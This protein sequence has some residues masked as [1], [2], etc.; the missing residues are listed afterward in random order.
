MKICYIIAEYNPFHLG[1]LRQ[2]E[3]VKNTLNAENVVVILSGNFTQRGE[4]AILD[5]YTRAKHCIAGGADLVIELPT[6]FATSNAEYFSK[7]AINVIS[8]LNA[9]GGLCF[10]AE[11]DDKEQFLS[12]ADC[13]NNETKE[14]KTSIKEELDNGVGLAKAKYNAIKKVYGDK[15]NARLFSLPNN[16]LGL[17]Y[18]RAI[19][20]YKAPLSIYPFKRDDTHNDITLKKGITSASSIRLKIEEGKIK[21]LKKSLPSFV[22]SDIKPINHDID[23][24]IMAALITKSAKE[25]SLTPDCSEGLENRL[26]ALYKDNIIYNDFISKTTTKRYTSARIRRILICNLLGITETLVATASKSGLYAKVL[27]VKEDKKS[28][29]SELTKTASVPILTRKSDAEK[30]K[31][32]AKDC[33]NIDVLANDIFALSV[34]AKQNENQMIIV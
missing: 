26:K 28:L 20:S 1:H 8:S 17:E 9:E 18:T 19:L 11:T 34:N 12:L 10:G 3:Y 25:I 14:F 31:G 7:G 29:I 24:I 6:V 23:K 32:L 13:L 33:F 27:A 16:I 15:Y 21:K 22:Y 5:K 4:M 2:I 30:L